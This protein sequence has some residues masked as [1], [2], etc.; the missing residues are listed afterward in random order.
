M[1]RQTIQTVR[2]HVTSQYVIDLIHVL[3]SATA[4]FNLIQLI[5]RNY[6]HLIC[7]RLDGQRHVEVGEIGQNSGGCRSQWAVQIACFVFFFFYF[8]QE[9]SQNSTKGQKSSELYLTGLRQITIL[10]KKLG[11]YCIHFCNFFV[12]QILINK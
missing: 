7:P 9:Q 4:D 10:D 6:L 1:H 5:T 2:G 3:Q 8:C 11:F 12:W